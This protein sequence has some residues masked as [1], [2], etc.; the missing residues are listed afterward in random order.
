MQRGVGQLDSQIPLCYIRAESQRRRETDR[1]WPVPD[2]PTCL[3]NR[4]T[5]TERER[6]I[7][8]LP[9]REGKAGRQADA[10]AI[11]SGSSSHFPLLLTCMDIFC[12]YADIQPYCYHSK[13][14]SHL[15]ILDS[16]HTVATA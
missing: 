15:I 2:R 5:G 11:G 10:S 4:N 3:T 13:V 14:F 12:M 16:M 7:A 6:V 9:R 1:P 8:R